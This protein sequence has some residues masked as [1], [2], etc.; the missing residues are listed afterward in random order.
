MHLDRH[1][2]LKDGYLIL[3]DL[4]H[5]V[6][7]A[8]E[9]LVHREWPDGPDPGRPP[10]QPRIYGFEKHVDEE[11]AAALEFCMHENIMEASR[12]L[13]SVQDVGLAYMY[14]MRN[15]AK[16]YGPWWWHRDYSHRD[17]PLQ[18]KQQNFIDNGPAHL[19]W[20]IAL[21][22]EEILWAVPGSH[23]RPST[24][25]EN[26]QLG[27]VDHTYAHGQMPQSEKRHTPL[28][29]SVPV[30]LKT[31]D[32][33][34]YAN[35]ILHWGSDYSTRPRRCIHIGTRGIS[36]SR[37]YQDGFCTHENFRY[38]SR[39]KQA[40]HAR[41]SDLYA[42]ECNVKRTTLQ[43]VIDKDADTFSKGL[44]R[45]HPAESGRLTC[46]IDLCGAV[47]SAMEKGDGTHEGFGKTE[48][49]LLW[50]RFA[51]LEQ[52]LRVEG[53]DYLPSFLIQER[54]PY[55]IYDMPEDYDL[56]SFVRGWEA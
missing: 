22:D 56:D 37:Y 46:L 20:N 52:A 1:R 26:R 7:E 40:E 30:D 50:Q 38:L 19:Q 44:A 24:E 5:S 32:G 2:F 49:S 25:A 3:R 48:T 27:A 18:G 53:G 55:R 17:G 51:S 43:A 6:R 14:F 9:S 10:F 16:D 29:D 35:M 21:L 47:R 36:G 4:L 11:T 15:P 12:Q 23:V 31:G 28:P 45:L 54:V 8:F 41:L 42:E 34:V 33:V 13:L 39:E